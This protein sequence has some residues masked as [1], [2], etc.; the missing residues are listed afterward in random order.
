[1]SVARRIA[2]TRL[3]LQPYL[4]SN[5]DLVTESLMLMAGSGRVPLATRSY[6]R[7]TPV[8]VSSEI[9]RMPRV[10]RVLVEHHVGEVAAVVED[11]VER[12]PSLKA[13]RVCSM[14]QSNSSRSCLSRRTRDTGSG[15][16]RSGVVLGG[17][18]IAGRP[19]YFG[20]QFHQGFDQHGGLDGHVQAAGDAGAFQG[21]G[22]RQILRGA[23]SD[24]AFLLRRVD[25]FAAPF[26]QGD[27]FYFVS[28]V[29]RTCNTAETGFGVRDISPVKA[30]ADSPGS[31]S[32]TPPGSKLP[33]LQGSLF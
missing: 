30:C 24:R 15:N 22:W 20:A 14:H 28:A 4:L 21:F 16:G 18:N 26:G 11:H 5:F 3:S 29:K 27:V 23:P 12:L 7:C 17:E 10:L 9:P 19:G 33:G 25:F 13:N 1:M 32:E 2:S 31:R 6:R 8:V